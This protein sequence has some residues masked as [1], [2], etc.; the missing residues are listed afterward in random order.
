MFHVPILPRKTFCGVNDQNKGD[1]QQDYTDGDVTTMQENPGDASTKKPSHKK[2]Y[3]SIWQIAIVPT[4]HFLIKRCKEFC[5]ID[6]FRSRG[7]RCL[8]L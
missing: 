6:R 2:W 3:I 4:W 8:Y 1:D 5:G 7:L